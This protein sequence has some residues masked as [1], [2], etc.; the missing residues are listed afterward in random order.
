MVMPMAQI[1]YLWSFSPVVTKHN[2]V[3]NTMRAMTSVTQKPVGGYAISW[4]RVTGPSPS[5][6]RV[7]EGYRVEVGR[8]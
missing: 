1:K 3:A 2:A 8:G 6:F 5:V 7:C 4:G